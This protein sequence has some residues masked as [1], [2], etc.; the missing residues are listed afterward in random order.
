MLF[1][2]RIAELLERKCTYVSGRKDPDFLP[3]AI[4]LTRWFFSE[5]MIRPYAFELLAQEDFDRARFVAHRT[6]TIKEA[7]VLRDRLTALYPSAITDEA[8]V[9]EYGF[10]YQ[11][12]LKRFVNI[13]GS[14]PSQESED[15]EL[16]RDPEKDSTLAGKLVEILTRRRKRRCEGM[17]RASSRSACAMTSIPC[18]GDTSFGIRSV[19]IS[20]KPLQGGRFADSAFYFASSTLPRR[21]NLTGSHF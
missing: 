15:D 20:S 7:V 21:E 10:E 11:A 18:E 3:E 1:D 4:R 17:M 9:D 2:E 6:R 8:S 5:E 19:S 13:H 14:P 12:S 16:E